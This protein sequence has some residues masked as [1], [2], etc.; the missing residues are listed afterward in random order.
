MTAFNRCR[1]RWVDLHPLWR[2]LAVVAVVAGTGLAAGPP[3]LGAYRGWQT[4]RQYAAA[5][6]ASENGQ[7]S[8]AIE[9]S[10]QVLRA[11]PSR[12]ELLPVLFRASDALGDSRRIRFARLLLEA[13]EKHLGSDRLWAWQALCGSAPAGPVFSLWEDLPPDERKNAAF[14]A[15]LI[16]RMLADGMII[17]AADLLQEH[18]QP[19]P[20]QLNQRLMRVLLA[21]GNDGSFL[22]F[23]ENLIARLK[24][25]ADGVD[26]LVPLLDVVPQEVLSAT[27]FDPL[28]AWEENEAASD[29]PTVLRLARCEMAAHPDR[30]DGVFARILAACGGKDPLATARWCLDVRRPEAARELL[31]GFDPGEDAE[32]F[33][34]LCRIHEESGDLAGWAAT[35]DDPPPGVFLPT[36]VCDRAHIASLTGE[37]TGLSRTEEAA[38]QAAAGSLAEDALIRLARH[39]EFREMQAFANRVWVEAIRRGTGPLPAGSRLRSVF[40]ELAVSGKEIEL[41]DALTVY[42]NFEPRNPAIIVQHGYLSCL[43]GHS[44]PAILAKDLAPIHARLPDFKPV[45]GVLAF[46]RLL[47]GRP[48]EAVALTDG[49]DFARPD[50]P[51]SYRAIRGIA[52]AQLGRNDEASE[53]LEEVRWDEMLSSERR[54]LRGLMETAGRKP[55]GPVVLHPVGKG[56]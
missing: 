7:H 53:L 55:P 33:A 8:A 23:Q 14:V 38:L 2:A 27:V 24:A 11:E 44:T 20:P 10:L 25:R 22:V 21:T 31:A 32:A 43:T 56:R 41:L 36:V 45:R 35:L 6:A 47:E 51:P 49:S 34:I 3:L 15:P 13:G 4:S 5:I 37:T 54:I 52:L 1:D 18:D 48:E 9:L 30:A 26:L 19:L 50:T 17:E 16:D 29:P 46:A 28:A 39:A 12:K 40:E 42:R